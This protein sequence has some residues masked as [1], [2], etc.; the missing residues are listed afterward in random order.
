MTGSTLENNKPFIGENN[1]GNLKFEPY[2]INLVKGCGWRNDGRLGP[3]TGE[4]LD[5][6]SNPYDIQLDNDTDACLRDTSMH[7]I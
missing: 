4:V 5:T 3:F 2:L 7:Q 6:S 1:P